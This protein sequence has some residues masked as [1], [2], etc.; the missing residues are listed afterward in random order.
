MCG[1][2]GYVGPRP[3]GPTLL[4]GLQR[5]E[6]RGYD[7]SGI[8]ILDK[9]GELI[10]EKAV[11][12][13]STLIS[14]VED[15]CLVGCLGIGHTRWATHGKPTDCNAH[16]HIDCSGNVAVIHNGIVENYMELKTEL[17]FLGHQFRSQTDT[18]VLPHL[19]EHF[20]RQGADLETAL[21]EAIRRIKGAHAIIALSKQEPDRIVGARIGNAGG[22]VVGYGQNE[23][24]IASD[25]PA[26][27]PY[28]RD[29]VFLS[30]LEMVTLTAG[31]ASYSTVDGNALSKTPQTT[32]YD[33]VAAAKG[34]YKHFMLKEIMEQ[35]E[36]VTDTIRGR[37]EFEPPNIYLEDMSFTD[38]D[39]QEI[40]K[41]IIV[42]CGTSMYAA[43]VA[44]FM[45]EDLARIPTEVDYGSEYRYREPIIDPGTLV[46]SVGQSGETVDTLAAMEE[47]KRQGARQITVC[48][49]VGSQ[50]T[51]VADAVVYLRAGMEIGV[52]AT[53][54]FTTSLTALY[55]LA[56]YLAKAR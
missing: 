41:V 9:N 7:S 47:A 5:L 45:I 40:K 24:Y 30:S 14:S 22:L 21:R 31:G 37:V 10:I 12:K 48:N 38:K 54:T 34:G 43:L 42:A 20:I 6:Y 32:P 27:L 16:P 44:K 53:K 56:T 36:A 2:I 4:E 11:G 15:N 1:I 13:L 33:M 8:A 25:L 28:T 52:A 17:L 39:L 18:E 50:A 19:I 3:V 51:R 26:I 29:M 35:P 55:L 49:V 46:I 23:M